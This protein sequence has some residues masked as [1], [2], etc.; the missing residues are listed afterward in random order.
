MSVP[1]V[2]GVVKDVRDNM[3]HTHGRVIDQTTETQQKYYGF[4]DDAL[5][6]PPPEGRV[7]VLLSYP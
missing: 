7:M 6:D 3:I 2:V 5:G 1:D 4:A